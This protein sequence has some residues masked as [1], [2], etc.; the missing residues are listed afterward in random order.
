[1]G[2]CASTR[3]EWQCGPSQV[4]I[5]NSTLLSR[6]KAVIGG[7]DDMETREPQKIL[8]KSTGLTR[9]EQALIEF[10]RT[11]VQFGTVTIFVQ[12]SQPI[13]IETGIRSVK[14]G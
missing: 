3:W 11:Q 8:D 10:I 6:R 2:G 4:L 12:D 13:R 14:L 7:T 9:R 1:M 5:M